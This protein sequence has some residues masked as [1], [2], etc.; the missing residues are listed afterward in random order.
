MML[1]RSWEGTHPL[2]RVSLLGH[3]DRS[4]MDITSVVSSGDVLTRD[5]IT[6]IRE[7]NLSRPRFVERCIPVRLSR[8]CLRTLNVPGLDE[9]AE[10]LPDVP[11]RHCNVFDDIGD[12]ER[13]EEPPPRPGHCSLGLTPRFRH[14]CTSDHR[15]GISK[16]ITCPNSVSDGQPGSRWGIA[17]RAVDSQTLCNIAALVLVQGIHKVRISSTSSRYLDSQQVFRYTHSA[18]CRPRSD[19]GRGTARAVLRQSPYNGN[20]SLRR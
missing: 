18:G 19:I 11:A 17:D 5:D 9:F 8:A 15:Q 10:H 20:Q 13:I 4:R 7:D 6:P 2:R 1:S 14:L 12:T 16:P 3:P